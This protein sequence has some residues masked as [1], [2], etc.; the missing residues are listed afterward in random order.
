MTE[1]GNTIPHSYVL[2]IPNG[3]HEIPAPGSGADAAIRSL[4]ERLAPR[5]ESVEPLRFALAGVVELSTML[6]PGPRRNYA[7]VVD[8]DQGIADA[9]MSI[10]LSRVAP[11][12]FGQYLAAIE[13]ST[14]LDPKIETVT[15]TV[16]EL[17]LQAG[18]AILLKDVTVKREQEGLIAGAIERAL[19][20]VFVSEA[21]AMLEILVA[22][23]N[24]ARFH[25][26]GEYTRVVAAAY[27][28]D[29]A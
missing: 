23:R 5:K 4:A 18:P 21:P 3:W 6:K 15:R 19:L 7:L 24:L 29:G 22:T 14:S 1:T 13:S 17:T 16:T 20:S 25:D 8:A 9:L 27:G 28:P 26:I 2:P 10:R 11:E 12:A